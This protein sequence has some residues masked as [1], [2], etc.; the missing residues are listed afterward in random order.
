MSEGIA[1]RSGSDVAA[2]CS[3]VPNAGRREHEVSRPLLAARDVP[4]SESG[5]VL[6]ADH[7]QA[8]QLALDLSLARDG[9]DARISVLDVERQRVIRCLS[10]EQAVLVLRRAHTGAAF[11]HTARA[12]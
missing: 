8:L 1:G 2:P 4:W 6:L 11:G 3:G 5:S 9:Y 7:L 10:L 12:R